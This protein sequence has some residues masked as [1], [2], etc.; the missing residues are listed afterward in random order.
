MDFYSTLPS[1]PTHSVALSL[2][3][4]VWSNKDS[5]IIVHVGEEMIQSWLYQELCYPGPVT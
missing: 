4:Y 3:L 1:P 5:E 2:I